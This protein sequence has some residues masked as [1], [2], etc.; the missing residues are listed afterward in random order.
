MAGP[1]L[2]SFLSALIFLF[3]NLAA[4]LCP[5][6]R[7]KYSSKHKANLTDHQ[8]LNFINFFWDIRAQHFSAICSDVNIVFDPDSPKL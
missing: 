5:I 4:G 1:Y 7:I 2:G 3:Y 6:Y 8:A